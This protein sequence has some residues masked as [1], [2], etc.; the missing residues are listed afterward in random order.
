MW[1]LDVCCMS[2][3]MWVSEPC[4]TM[5]GGS[6]GWTREQVSIRY[7]PEREGREGGMRIIRAL[8]ICLTCCLHYGPPASK[9]RERGRGK[10]IGK[11]SGE[12]SKWRSNLLMVK[13]HVVF[14]G[15]SSPTGSCCSTKLHLFYSS[16]H[17][18]NIHVNGSIF[19]KFKKLT[20]FHSIYIYI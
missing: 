4:G 12:G 3:W 8:G 9:G 20:C 10:S 5:P 7:R 13:Y 14:L 11:C 19:F 16:M 2:V 1:W 18:N 15:L 6:A 17:I